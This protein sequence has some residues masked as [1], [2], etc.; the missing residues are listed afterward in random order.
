MLNIKSTFMTRGNHIKIVFCVVPL[1]N[2]RHFFMNWHKWM[3]SVYWPH[4]SDH[5]NQNNINRGSALFDLLNDKLTVCS[6][7]KS[8]LIIVRPSIYECTKNFANISKI[9]LWTFFAPT[10]F[11]RL[12]GY[13]GLDIQVYFRSEHNT[14]LESERYENHNR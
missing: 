9:F 10:V 6:S 12:N 13:F 1:I 14:L 5:S 7:L 11:N 8:S 4:L 2:Y 3:R